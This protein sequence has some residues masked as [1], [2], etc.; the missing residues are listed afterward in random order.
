MLN[1]AL[2]WSNSLDRLRPRFWTSVGNYALPVRADIPSHNFLN[3][4]VVQIALSLY[5]AHTGS[6]LHRTRSHFVSIKDMSEPSNEAG[7]SPS[8]EN[9]KETAVN[10]ETDIFLYLLTKSDKRLHRVLCGASFQL[11]CKTN[12]SFDCITTLLK[13]STVDELSKN[14]TMD[15]LTEWTIWC[16]SFPCLYEETSRML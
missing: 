4:L 14:G 8:E 6:Q 1:A 16:L 5:F 3:G 2:R 13:D 10:I 9:K 11:S 7:A 15:L 12:H